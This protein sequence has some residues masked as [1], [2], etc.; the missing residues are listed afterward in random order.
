LTVSIEW[1]DPVSAAVKALTAFPAITAST[2][3]ASPAAGVREFVY[4]LYPGAVET[5][6]VAN[7]EVQGG[8]LPRTLHPKVTHSSTGSW[9]YSLGYGLVL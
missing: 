6:A 8:S 4:E 5:A 9:T 2:L 7:H 1:V 3:G